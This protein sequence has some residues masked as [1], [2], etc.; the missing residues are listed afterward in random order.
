MEQYA[1][2]LDPTQLGLAQPCD[3]EVTLADLDMNFFAAYER[4]APFGNAHTEPLFLGRAFRLCAQPRVIKERHVAL[5]FTQGKGGSA[6]KATAW[7]RRTHWATRA[8][9]E[10]WQ[11]GHCFDVVFRLTRNW[12]PE[13]G[14]WEL[15]VEQMR[16]VA[17]QGLARN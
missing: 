12:H 1:A 7:S 4:L 3:A 8:M 5:R 2:T 13:F 11:P 10:A 17:E 16:Q 6:W 9:Q 15:A 14:G